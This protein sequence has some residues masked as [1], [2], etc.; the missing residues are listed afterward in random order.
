MSS[1]TKWVIRLSVAVFAVSYIGGRALRVSRTHQAAPAPIPLAQAKL[2]SL[3]DYLGRQWEPCFTDAPPEVD[4]LI[5]EYPAKMSPEDRKKAE[6]L[7]KDDLKRIVS[8]ICF[9]AKK[10]TK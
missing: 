9:T 10:Q 2:I 7:F 4:Y 3:D 5:V 1:R 6:K 8:S